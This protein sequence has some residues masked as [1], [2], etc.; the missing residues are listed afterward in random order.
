[1]LASQNN[2]FPGGSDG[3]TRETRV[4]SLGREDP[5][6]KAMATHSSTLAW[7]IPWT[8]EP[9]RLQS[10]GLQRVRHDWV[11]SLPEQWQGSR[12]PNNKSPEM[13]SLLQNVPWCS[14]GVR[15]EMAMDLHMKHLVINHHYEQEQS[16]LTFTYSETFLKEHPLMN[17]FI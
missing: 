7:K 2:S 17:K 5:Q 14:P 12:A 10:M 6:E 13:L 4:W 9:G 3:K 8:E 1:M 15:L 11:T 16:K